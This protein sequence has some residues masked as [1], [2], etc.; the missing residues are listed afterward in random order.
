MLWLKLRCGT[1]RLLA[2]KEVRVARP[3]R[4][5]RLHLLWIFRNFP[6][7]SWQVLSRRQRSLVRKLYATSV[8]ASRSAD[9]ME[10]LQ[11]IG[12]IECPAQMFCQ[13][14]VEEPLPRKAVAASARS[15]EIQPRALAASGSRVRPAAVLSGAGAQLRALAG[16]I[17]ATSQKT[18]KLLPFPIRSSAPRSLD[19]GEPMRAPATEPVQARKAGWRKLPEPVLLNRLAVGVL[20]ALISILAFALRRDFSRQ[21]APDPQESATHF[22]SRPRNSFPSPGTLQRPPAPELPDSGADGNTTSLGAAAV[23]TQPTTNVQ[24]AST[25]PA[26]VQPIPDASEAVEPKTEVPAPGAPAGSNPPPPQTSELAT[27]QEPTTSPSADLKRLQQAP[28]SGIVFPSYP[29]LAW[30]NGQRGAVVLRAEVAPAGSISKVE[31]VSGDPTLAKA[32]A[33]ALTRWR[34]PAQTTPAEVVVRF[35]FINPEAISVSFEE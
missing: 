12:T 35:N 30:R 20:I 34:Y 8:P 18:G 28:A 6:T 17:S 33:R 19:T 22:D 11:T 16:T 14:V 27:A 21:L 10:A 9:L 5:E 26:A 25:Q 29:P 4:L 2:G 7:L 13:P 23:P 24:A 1:L 31:V 15:Q 32:A 3:A